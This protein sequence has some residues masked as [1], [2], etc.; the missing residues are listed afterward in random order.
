M[1]DSHSLFGPSK[2]EL[3][4]Q[5]S[6][7]IDATYVPAGFWEGAKVV[8]RHGPWT[9]T[10]D[11]HSVSAGR[12]PI[13]FTRLRAPYVNHDGFRFTIYRQGI[14]SHVG[15]WLGMQDVVVGYPELDHEFVIQGN[16]EAK[17]SSLLGD[18]RLRELIQAEPSIQLS[19]RDDEGWFSETFPEGVDELNLQVAGLVRDVARL[20]SLYELFAMLLDRLCGIGSAD[21]RT[22]PLEP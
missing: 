14:F 1:S 11:T 7:E 22:P 9:I 20:K 3:W 4:Q 19:V 12:T 5:L 21:Q 18:R 13:L 2:A 8:A 6:R 17:L 16:N 10:L 15:K